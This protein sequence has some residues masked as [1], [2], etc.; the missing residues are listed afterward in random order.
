MKNI[1]L[2]LQYLNYLT[3]AKTLHGT[4]SDFV[5][6]FY[7]K[8]VEGD[9]QYYDFGPIEH[10]RSLLI[11]S[12]EVIDVVDFGAGSGG[13]TKRMVKDIASRSAIA[14]KQGRVLFRM[15][16]FMQ[17]K[18][19]LEIGTSLGISTLYQAKACPD[20]NFITMEGSPETAKLAAKNFQLLKANNIK[21][22]TG[23]FDETLPRVLNSI[24][25]LNYVFF[26][27][28]H[29][30]EPTLNYFKQCLPL[31]VDNTVF[32][33]DDIRWSTGMYRAW[34][35]IIKEP[36]ATVTIDMF[37]FGII[38]FRKGQVKQHFTLKL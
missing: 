16:N 34:Q 32:V 17:P 22:V 7:Q 27:G 30:M 19:M 26:D 31:A 10:L 8:V 6:R 21:Q 12:K 38:F 29:K 28:N 3:R 5:Y 4:H 20:A 25:S 13:S 33:F 36:S 9:L 2:P 15:V 1:F 14:A 35:K 11:H 24:S 37:S 23:N 18:T